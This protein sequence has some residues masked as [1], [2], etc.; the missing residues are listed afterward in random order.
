MWGGSSSH[1]CGLLRQEPSRS[2][3]AESMYCG[4][5]HFE[6]VNGSGFCLFLFYFIFVW[7]AHEH[8]QAVALAA[9]WSMPGVFS[10]TLSSLVWCFCFLFLRQGPSLTL[11]AQGIQSFPPSLKLAFQA[12]DT[13]PRSRNVIQDPEALFNLSK[14]KMELNA[15]VSK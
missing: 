10:S 9:H 5:S 7:F 13:M 11:E 15:L 6:A 3:T 14:P 1:R 4:L 12:G 2:P 8:A